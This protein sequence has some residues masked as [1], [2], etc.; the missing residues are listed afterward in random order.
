MN[1]NISTMDGAAFDAAQVLASAPRGETRVITPHYLE[2]GD[3]TFSEKTVTRN[4]VNL[5]SIYEPFERLTEGTLK[6]GVKVRLPLK[7]ALLQYPDAAEILRTGIRFLA[8]ERYRMMPRSFDGI[9]TYYDSM[10]PQEEYLRDAAIGQLPYAPSGQEVTEVSSSFEG[11]VTVVNNLYRGV[12]SILGDWIKFDQIGKIRQIPDLLA[13]SLRMTEEQR[14]YNVLTTTGNYTRNSTTNDNDV[15]ANTAATTFSGLGLELAVNTIGT[16]KD[17]KSGNYLGLRADTI[18]I[19]PRM[20]VPVKMLLMSTDLNRQGGNTTNEVRGTGTMNSYKGMLN[21]IIISPWFGT[22]ANA[23]QW[24]VFDSTVPWMVF[25][26]VEPAN[27][28]QEDANM[29]SE[30]WLKYDRIRF[31]AREYFGAGI[32]DDRGA[33]YSSSTTAPTVS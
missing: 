22:G 6:N 32:V 7:E 3:I 27:V 4:S 11:G 20:E 15:G 25:Q 16:S 10:K 33:F 9:V 8:F 26:T 13:R 28:F 14:V 19:G 5:T 2:S 17:R 1:N 23:Y 31:L 29:T 30:A 12:A 24:L 18:V 21:N